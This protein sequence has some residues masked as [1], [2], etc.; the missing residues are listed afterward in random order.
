MGKL[1]IVVLFL[2]L[3]LSSGLFAQTDFK[4]EMRKHKISFISEVEL[5]PTRYHKGRGLSFIGVY[6]FTD[7]FSV[8]LGIKPY[9]LFYPKH[10]LYYVYYTIDQQNNVVWHEDLYKDYRPDCEFYLPVY[11]TIKFVF[12][13]R[14][15]ASPYVE[16]RLGFETFEHVNELY[17]TLCLG[18]RFGFNGKYNRAVNVSVGWQGTGIAFET[19]NSFLFKVGYEF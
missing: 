5:T 12:S 9:I 11:T 3:F 10:R 4:T 17:R 19:S 15:N 13:K 8:G 18:S 1:T 2:F 7:Y 16:Y 6:N 14:T